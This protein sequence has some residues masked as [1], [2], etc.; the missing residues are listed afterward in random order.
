MALSSTNQAFARE[1]VWS[2]STAGHQ[3][4]CDHPPFRVDYLFDSRILVARFCGWFDT[5][6]AWQRLEAI[7]TELK[8][9][10]VEGVL[11]DI[12]DSTYT[13]GEGDARAF[14]A[15]FSSFLGRRRLAF[16]SR[17]VAQ[18]RMGALIADEAAMHG[19]SAKVFQDKQ[20]AEIW[21]GS[22]DR[23]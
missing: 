3:A 15:Y 21:L 10:V 5:T 11:L 7:S 9:R 1:S 23:R 13:S 19:V 12:R 22:T 4:D 2:G 6:C 16:I 14:A 18:C 17:S 8:C 20:R